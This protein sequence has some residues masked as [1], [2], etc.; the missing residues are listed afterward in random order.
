MMIV[1][2]R[3]LVVCGPWCRNPEAVTNPRAAILRE[4][5]SIESGDNTQLCPLGIVDSGSQNGEVTVLT[6]E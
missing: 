6:G 4:R 5:G 1:A 2:V 3:L